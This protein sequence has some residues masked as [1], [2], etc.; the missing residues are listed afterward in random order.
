[1]E[2]EVT[3][4]RGKARRQISMAMEDLAAFLA[5]HWGKTRE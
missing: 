2:S 1:V 3:V 4:S 5:E